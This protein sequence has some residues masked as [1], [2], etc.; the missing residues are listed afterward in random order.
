MKI[1]KILLALILTVIAVLLIAGL[2]LKKEFHVEREV[3]INKPKDQVF[4]YIK[5]VKNQDNFSK[6]NLMD[7]GMKKEYTGA[8]GTVGFVYKWES[9]NNKV[10][11]GEQSIT[12]IVEGERMEMSLHF[13]KPMESNAQC[14]MTTEAT[15]ASQT[16]VKWGFDTKMSYPMNVAQLFFDMDKEVGNDFQTGLNNLKAV[17]EKQ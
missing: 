1:V 8:D 11:Q 3:V 7:P 12:K 17:M 4:N 10:G 6:W 2:F 15:G 9:A 5:Y 16:K 13:V 14:F